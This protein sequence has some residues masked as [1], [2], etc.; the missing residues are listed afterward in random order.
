MNEQFYVYSA[1]ET[2]SCPNCGVEIDVQKA[3]LESIE[4]LEI[5]YIGG[6]SEIEGP[7]FQYRSSYECINCS[8]NYSIYVGI[9]GDAIVSY[10]YDNGVDPNESRPLM[11]GTNFTYNIDYKNHEFHVINKSMGE[12]QE[13]LMVLGVNQADF[14]EVDNEIKEQPMP[15]DKELLNRLKV[16]AHNYVSSAYTFKKIWDNIEQDLPTGNGVEGKL[17]DFEDSYKLIFGL[18]LYTQ[19]NL[20]LP[21]RYLEPVGANDERTPIVNLDDVSFMEYQGG[22]NDDGY[23]HSDEGADHHYKQV[24]GNHINLRERFKEFTRN[25]TRLAAAVEEQ[26][27]NRYSDEIQDYIDKVPW[28]INE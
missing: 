2:Q 18:R 28:I 8:E 15:V 22:E 13:A 19:K 7:K 9:N 26:V 5:G 11:F 14:S 1:L 12:L 6:A 23:K 27:H 17:D 4:E 20:I 25:S 21:I 24:D 10:F 16:R 3:K